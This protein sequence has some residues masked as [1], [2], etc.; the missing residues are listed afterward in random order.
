MLLYSVSKPFFCFVYPH[1][2]VGKARILFHQHMKTSEMYY[3][4][5]YTHKKNASLIL[6]WFLLQWFI[7][8]LRIHQVA[9]SPID[10]LVWSF[11]GSG[12]TFYEKGCNY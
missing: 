4:V 5:S 2:P 11:D 3:F 6:K 7:F 10:E 1:K 8:E 9:F 12:E